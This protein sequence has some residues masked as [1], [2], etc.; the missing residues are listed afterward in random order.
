MTGLSVR[1]I[2]LQQWPVGKRTTGDLDDVEL[3][4]LDD[5]DRWLV[6]R[7]RH[8]KETIGA[9]L[10]HQAVEILPAQARFGETLDVLDI[11]TPP[12]CRVNEGIQVAVLQLECEMK[13]EC[14]ANLAEGADHGHA[15]FDI[16][17][18]IVSH[19]QH[20]ERRRD[21]RGHQ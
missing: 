15:V 6:E 17:H 3:L 21:G 11:V 19:F 18:V 20:E 1:T 5:I 14:P 4:R 8:G 7:G 9:H 13:R 2:T 10:G 16:T 12:S